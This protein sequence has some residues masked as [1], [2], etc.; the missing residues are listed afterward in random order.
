[1]L[2]EALA[3]QQNGWNVMFPYVSWIQHEVTCFSLFFWVAFGLVWF[4]VKLGHILPPPDEHME[5]HNCCRPLRREDR[6]VESGNA[7][8]R[9]YTDSISTVHA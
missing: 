1:M 7:V 2:A 8:D 4:V 5:D 9:E 3:K 6:E